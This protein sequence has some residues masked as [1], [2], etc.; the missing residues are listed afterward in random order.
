MPSETGVTELFSQ[1]S[2][3]ESPVY[4]AECILN[5]ISLYE[6]INRLQ[7]IKDAGYD[8]YSE[9]KKL[10]DLYSKLSKENF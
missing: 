1:I 10:G 5:R 9:T 8:I 4:W 3:E 2:L 7:D 6:R